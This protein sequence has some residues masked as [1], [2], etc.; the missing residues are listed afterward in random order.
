L[1]DGVLL[2]DSYMQAYSSM[3]GGDDTPSMHPDVPPGN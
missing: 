3:M 1:S 2:S